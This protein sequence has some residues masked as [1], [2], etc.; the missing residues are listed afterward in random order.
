MSVSLL[1]FIVHSVMM[2][3]IVSPLCSGDFSLYLH[4][5]VFL[6]AFIFSVYFIIS[7]LKQTA[8]RTPV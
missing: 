3:L 1:V 7:Q 2:V 5:I 8:Q 6:V 4:V